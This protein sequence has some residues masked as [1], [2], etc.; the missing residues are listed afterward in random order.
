MGRA[1]TGFAGQ[2]GLARTAEPP[3]VEGLED[4]AGRE[5]PA[6][7]TRRS[8]VVTKERGNT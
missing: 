8:A 7:A 4:P 5:T 2:T 3:Q 1:A 6:T